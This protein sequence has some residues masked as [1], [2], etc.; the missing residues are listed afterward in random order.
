MGETQQNELIARKNLQRS[1][2]FESSSKI[3]NYQEAIPS[4]DKG[5]EAMA[6]DD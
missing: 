1:H 2:G 3:A 4:H 5:T 6:Q